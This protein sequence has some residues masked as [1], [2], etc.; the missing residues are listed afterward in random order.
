MRTYAKILVVI[1]GLL[2]PLSLS[3]QTTE[4]L[5]INGD[6][7]EQCDLGWYYL[8]VGADDAEAVRWWRKAAEQGYAE[9]QC[10]LGW[11]YYNGRGVTTRNYAEAVRW[12]RKAAEQGYAEAQCDLGWCCYNEEGVTLNYDEAVNWWRKAA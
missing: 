10:N 5:K 9:A 4:E 8:G 3:A 11:C 2:L 12:W 7:K 6:V 1:V